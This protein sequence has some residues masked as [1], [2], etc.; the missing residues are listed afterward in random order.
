MIGLIPGKDFSCFSLPLPHPQ[1]SKRKVD[2]HSSK[3]SLPPTA[4]G[5]RD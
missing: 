1:R 2:S 5:T 3:S 4:R